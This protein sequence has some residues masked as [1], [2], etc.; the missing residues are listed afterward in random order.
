VDADL[1]L[2]SVTQPETRIVLRGLPAGEENDKIVEHPGQPEFYVDADG[3]RWDWQS[4]Q[5]WRWV[6]GVSLRVYDPMP[7]N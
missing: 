3:V 7:S 6:D 4:D 1:G 5:A 2:A